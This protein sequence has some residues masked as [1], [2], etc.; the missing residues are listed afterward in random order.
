MGTGGSSD[1]EAPVAVVR[2]SRELCVGCSRPTRVCLC[3]VLPMEKVQCSCDMI[4]LQHPL[5][6]K[7]K[8]QSGWIAERCISGVRVVVGR[9]LVDR[10]LPGLACV[11]EDP[12]SCAVVFPCDSALPLNDVEQVRHLIFLDATWRFAK[13]MLNDSS[14]LGAIKRVHLTPPPS[15]SPQFVVRKPLLLDGSVGRR[16]RV[17]KGGLVETNAVDHP[18][19]GFSTAEAVALAADTLSGSDSGS[20][21]AWVAVSRVVRRLVA[22][23]LSWT[24]HVPH[25]REKPGYVHGLYDSCDA[26]GI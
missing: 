24:Q 10:E 22:L 15:V 17:P 19:W 1:G 21:S 7:Q 25:R 16:S 9:R 6:R 12:D 8:H 2:P 11:W 20:G 26:N 4:L 23:E 5:E 14:S 3:D 13:E 18:S